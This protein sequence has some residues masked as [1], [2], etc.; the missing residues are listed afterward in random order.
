M[1]FV[2]WKKDARVVQLFF[3]IWSMECICLMVASLL[4]YFWLW[5]LFCFTYQLIFTML[6]GIQKFESLWRFLFF[7]SLYINELL[8]KRLLWT[9]NFS[10]VLI[11]FSSKI[12]SLTCSFRSTKWGLLACGTLV[13]CL[14][15][16]N[17]F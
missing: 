12:V 8:V 17:F 9:T 3:L 15:L 1:K 4:R 7:G 5:W 13:Y 16:R 6:L 11:S 14:G 2:I 10:E